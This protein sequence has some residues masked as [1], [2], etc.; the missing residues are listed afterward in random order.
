LEELRLR[1]EKNAYFAAP[2]QGWFQ[3]GK[4]DG[5]HTS[6]PSLRDFQT[7]LGIDTGS[8]VLDPGFSDMPARDYRLSR[9]AMEKLKQCYPRG[10]V[11]ECVLGV[12]PQE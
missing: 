8:S 10:P 1:F 4:S 3:W 11:P 2:G 7:A 12:V 9:Q 6:Y 5:R